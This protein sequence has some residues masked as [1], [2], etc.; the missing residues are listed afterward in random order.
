[1]REEERQSYHY[2]LM[3]K[4][5]CNK[6]GGWN[7]GEFFAAYGYK[8]I[9]LYAVSEFLEIFLQ[10]I[11]QYKGAPEITVYDT[12]AD[13]IVEPVMGYKVQSRDELLRRI[14]NGEV[15]CIVICSLIHENAIFDDLM[16]RGVSQEKL[17][18]IASVIYSN[19]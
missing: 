3:K 4:Y 8:R 17:L 18:S 6:I 16:G 14:N 13:R 2:L 7:I 5:L 12:Y 11:A 15:D 9:A 10:D 19:K 1:M